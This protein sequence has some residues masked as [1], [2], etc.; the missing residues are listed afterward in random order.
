MKLRVLIAED[1]PI[2][3]ERLRQLLAAEKQVQ[4]VAECSNGDE[5]LAAIRKLRPDLVFLDIRMPARDGFEV[6]R[7]IDAEERPAIIFVTASAQFAVQAFEV[8]AVDYLLKPFDQER[9]HA[10]LER[11]RARLA[12]GRGQKNSNGEM[13][14]EKADGH[15]DRLAVKQGGRISLVQF[16]TIDWI[17]AAD[18]YAELHVG[19]ACHLLRTTITQLAEEL[20]PGRFVR[21]SRSTLVNVN[22]IKEIRSKTHG[23]YV[24]LMTSGAQLTATRTYRDNLMRSLGKRAA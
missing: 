8:H 20:P 6:V 14:R 17:V 15:L 18:N 3:R 16:E 13:T 5:T 2:S 22:R 11:A 23:D 21:I 4:I 7:E 24:V 9:L 10:A 12:G 1:E 19:A